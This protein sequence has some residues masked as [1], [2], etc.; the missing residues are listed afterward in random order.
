M[1]PRNAFLY[2]CYFILMAEAA[3]H[4]TPQLPAHLLPPPTPSP[5]HRRCSI[6][7]AA[8]S[9]RTIAPSPPLPSSFVS[10][11]R[12]KFIGAA[13]ANEDHFTPLTVPLVSMKPANVLQNVW[14]IMVG[15]G[16]YIK[17]KTENG[18]WQT[19]SSTITSGNAAGRRAQLC[20]SGLQMMRAREETSS[21]EEQIFHG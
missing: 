4:S 14:L 11:R 9:G 13:L 16:A 19:C 7:C 6:V 1:P 3:D 10:V 12:P 5:T 8:V 18:C 21:G 20:F 17:N 2:K 15:G